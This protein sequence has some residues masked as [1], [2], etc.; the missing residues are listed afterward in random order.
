MNAPRKPF[1]SY[2]W[3]WA[4]LTPTESLNDPVVYL[5]VLR[6]L[7]ESEGLPPNSRRVASRLRE[8]QT[9]TGTRVNLVRTPDRNLIRHSGQYWKAL[10]LLGDSSGEISLTDFGR[11]VARGGITKTEFALTVV[12]TLELPN[13]RIETDVSEWDEAGLK[14]KP[15]E[16]IM[17]IISA[18]NKSSG[19]EQAYV[20]P[21]ELVSIIIPLAGARSSIEEH[22][23]ALSL[24]RQGSLDLS[25]WPEC[26]PGANDPRMA[27][28]FLLFLSYYGICTRPEGSPKKQERFSLV[29]PLLSK[30]E[31]WESL[32]LTG[33]N[34]SSAVRRVRETNLPAVADRGRVLAEITARP[35]QAAFRNNLLI[36]FGSQ[37][38]ITGVNLEAV[39]E[40]IHI[41][42]VNR[43]GNDRIENGLCLRTD[44]HSLFDSGHLRLNASG[45]IHLSET[46]SQ[47]RN[48]GSL[49][50]RITIPP[51]VNINNIDWRWKYY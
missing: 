15:L 2:K 44:M 32:D 8:V 45:S 10:D 34:S 17:Q 28:E 24:Y 27:R 29:Q 48:Y 43:G 23:E 7:A 47:R 20:T 21:F 38:I 49:P 22:I 42:P 40:A 5:G 39:L 9:E 3:R 37:C 25:A 1:P 33:E 31:E 36:A 50:S 16:L 51:F 35:H 41:V 18:L 19:Q 12:K 30:L 13:R 11:R 6:V 26:A 46:A 4:T 14:I